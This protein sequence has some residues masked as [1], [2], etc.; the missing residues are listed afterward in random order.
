MAHLVQLH[1]HRLGGAVHSLAQVDEH[2]GHGAARRVRRRNRHAAGHRRHAAGAPDACQLG[3]DP[4]GHVIGTAVGIPIAYIMPMTA[5]PQRTAH[6]ARMRRAGGG[7]GGHG[8]VLPRT[9]NARPQF[10]MVALMIEDAARLPHLH[11]QPDG[12]GQAAG[13]AAAAAHHLRNQ[14]VVNFTL[15]AIAAGAGR[16][17]DRGSHRTRGSSRSSRASR[18]CSACC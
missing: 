17:A 4:G 13:G 8:R 14:N 16:A 12:H 7:A 6:V 11:G 5:V 15:F 3:M 1:L 10:M 9:R 2:A 18:C